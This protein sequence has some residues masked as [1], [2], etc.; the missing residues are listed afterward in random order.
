MRNLNLKI[1]TLVIAMLFFVSVQFI[2][3][4]EDFDY[5][6][7]NVLEYSLSSLRG[8]AQEVSEHNKW[9]RS[10][11]KS[12]KTE[13]K[14]AHKALKLLEQETAVLTNNT[15]EEGGELD[16]RVREIHL[17]KKKMIRFNHEV[18]QLH[19]E[20]LK[21]EK[22]LERKQHK[23]IR[24]QDQ[25]ASAI[26]DA[27][28]KR[29]GA[30]GGAQE[31]GAYVQ[32]HRQ[33]QQLVGLELKVEG[34]IENI[35]DE[36]QRIRSKNSKPIRQ[37]TAL[38][39]Q[40]SNLRNKVYQL[41]EELNMVSRERDMTAQSVDDVKQSKTTRINELEDKI[42]QL[43]KR[44]SELEEYFERIS[45]KMMKSRM[46]VDFD[47]KERR[48]EDNLLVVKKENTILNLEIEQIKREIRKKRGAR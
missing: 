23:E 9:L 27:A 32:Y 13:K 3:A 43:Q 12:L 36:I 21:L 41:E 25:L 38:Q 30:V 24:L 35:K 10:E 18:Q 33:K 17:T 22:E 31:D 8:R 6:T 28:R 42:V 2:E 47:T 4:V 16:T 20:Q 39:D 15:T 40:Q 29:D 48:L 11:I 5:S 7:R 37:Y 45:R 19:Q 14:R 46:Q 44:K 1:L 34:S 26:E